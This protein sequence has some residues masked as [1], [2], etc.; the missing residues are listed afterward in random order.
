MYQE[1][2]VTWNLNRAP[3]KPVWQDV[4]ESMRSLQ[5]QLNSVEKYLDTW[6]ED[7]TKGNVSMQMVDT[8]GILDTKNMMKAI[9]TTKLDKVVGRKM[10][11]WEEIL[12]WVMRA[13]KVLGIPTWMMDMGIDIHMTKKLGTIERKP[14]NHKR[15]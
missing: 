14:M 10:K 5:L 11:Q 1:V 6:R 7:W 9:L 15:A 4:K 3:S 13:L 8:M 12:E 2:S